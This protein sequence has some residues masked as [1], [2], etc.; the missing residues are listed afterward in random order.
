MFFIR[1]VLST[2]DR[3][4]RKVYALISSLVCIKSTIIDNEN[5]FREQ[6]AHHDAKDYNI[7]QIVYVKKR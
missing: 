4:K 6:F 7:L 5:T 2:R 3:R 1:V